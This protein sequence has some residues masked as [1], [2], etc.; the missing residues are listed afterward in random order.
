MSDI[1]TLGM[2]EMY[3]SLGIPL[4]NW[5]EAVRCLKE[6][7]ITLLGEP[8]AAEVTPYFDHIIQ[9]LAYP[10]VPYFM[11]EGVLEY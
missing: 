5:V 7:A 4:A 1:G 2:K 9:A 10:G 11:N 6:E 8:D 3:N